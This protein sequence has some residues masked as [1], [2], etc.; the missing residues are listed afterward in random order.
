MLKNKGY[1]LKWSR[2]EKGDD[3]WDR[4]ERQTSTTPLVFVGLM[5]EKNDNYFSNNIEQK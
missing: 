5:S 3:R 2:I 4:K 1:E